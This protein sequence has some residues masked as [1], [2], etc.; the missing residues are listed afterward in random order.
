MPDIDW[1]GTPNF[2]SRNGRSIIAIV[3]HITAGG[4][5]GC[6][7]WLQNPASQASVHYLVTRSGLIKQLV[8]DSDKAWHAGVID[9]CDWSLYDNT[10]PNNYTL[11]IEHEGQPDVSLTEE[12]YQASLWLHKQLIQIHSISIDSEHIIAHSRINKSHNCPGPAFPWNRLFS[13]LE[14][15]NDMLNVAVLLFTKEDFWAGMD[16]SAKNGYCAVFVR[17]N[18]TTI[19]AEAF[20]AHQLI[21]VGG[22]TTNHPN[23][24]LLSGNDKYDTASAVGNYLK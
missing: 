3:D 6:L 16:V 12:Q 8:K 19:P 21:V 5:P 2:S 13:D 14:G 22:P 23:E 11:G 18:P 17:P 15:G 9:R 7:D 10:N 4:Y 24:I 1:V 20:S